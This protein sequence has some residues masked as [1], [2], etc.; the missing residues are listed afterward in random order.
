MYLSN[1]SNLST[2]SHLDLSRSIL[3]FISAEWLGQSDPFPQCLS[4]EWPHNLNESEDNEYVSKLKITQ[5]YILTSTLL[6]LLLLLARYFQSSEQEMKLF[7]MASYSV[8]PLVSSVTVKPWE[9]NCKTL[10]WRHY[11][12]PLLLRR[13]YRY[14]KVVCV[15]VCVAKKI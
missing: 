3:V 6:L 5:L 9:Q 4:L 14:V 12:Q 8:G 1:C 7:S 15:C 13:P 11:R 2:F 10:A